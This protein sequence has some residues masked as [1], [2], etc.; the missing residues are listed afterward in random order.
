VIIIYRICDQVLEFIFFGLLSYLRVRRAELGSYRCVEEEDL[1]FEACFSDVK[2]LANFWCS[3]GSRIQQGGSS[4]NIN[5][6]EDAWQY[7]FS[8]PIDWW[9][10]R[11]N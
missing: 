9:D 7:Y 5:I 8:C 6:D 10:N 11:P 1:F 4:S 2:N 3:K